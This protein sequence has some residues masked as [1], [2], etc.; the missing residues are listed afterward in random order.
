MTAE[1]DK[2]RRLVEIEAD[3]RRAARHG[4]NM[5]ILLAV[6][7]AAVA[8]W[9]TTPDQ[10]ARLVETWR[11]DAIHRQ[12]CQAYRAVSPDKTYA[13]FPVCLPSMPPPAADGY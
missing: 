10:R 3:M 6:L 11:H 7:A 1:K 8:A 4:D 9:M 5:L 2:P 12:L 13:N